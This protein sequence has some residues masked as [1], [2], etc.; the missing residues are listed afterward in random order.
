MKLKL[1]ALLT[2]Y[3]SCGP[4]ISSSITKLVW[5]GECRGVPLQ[6]H[7]ALAQWLEHSSLPGSTK[8]TNAQEEEASKQRFVEL[9]EVAQ[10]YRYQ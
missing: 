9:P 8:S 1:R 2:V 4:V 5:F 7:Q 10:V 6:L 3:T